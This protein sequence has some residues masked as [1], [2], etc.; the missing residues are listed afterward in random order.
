[1][2]VTLRE[3]FGFSTDFY[4]FYLMDEG[5]CPSAPDDWNSQ[6]TLAQRLLVESHIIS[7]MTFQMDWLEVDLEVC[8]P[9][10]T[11]DPSLWD[12]VVEASLEVPT[13]QLTVDTCLFGIAKR[14]RVK[15]GWYR[16]LFCTCGIGDW[17]TIEEGEAIPEHYR[18]TL[19]PAPVEPVNI[20]KQW[21]GPVSP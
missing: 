7:V 2:V 1:M 4:Q 15:P 17:E 18:I 3:S 12:H 20:I 19:W 16:I 11:V 8:E 21:T 10:P 5:M 6:D 13:G 9:M 14:L